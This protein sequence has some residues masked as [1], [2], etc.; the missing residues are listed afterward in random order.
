[1]IRLTG[2]HDM[3]GWTVIYSTIEDGVDSFTMMAPHDG[4]DAWETAAEK[5]VAR[6]DSDSR[7]TLYAIIKGMNPAYI[8][9]RGS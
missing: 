7:A 3:L 1:M 9:T 4:P 2:E 8:K 6:Y 5:L